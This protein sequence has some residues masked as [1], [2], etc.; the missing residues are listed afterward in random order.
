MAL[1]VEGVLALLA[2]LIVGAPAIHFGLSYVAPEATV[3]PHRA[4]GI[5]LF[6][7]L[8]WG[9]VSLFFGWIPAIG[10][11]LPPLAWIGTVKWATATDWPAATLV[12]LVTWALTT[13]AYRGV[14]IV[15]A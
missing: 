3:A 5:A 1:L 8:A 6:G 14:G 11:L 9:L 13:L 15:P 4:V 10:L 7:A 2:T 12:G